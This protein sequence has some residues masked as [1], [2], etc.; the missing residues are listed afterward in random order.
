MILLTV[1]TAPIL[2]LLLLKLAA[3]AS[4]TDASAQDPAPAPAPVSAPTAPE[5]AAP[6]PAPAPPQRRPAFQPRFHD[7]STPI[8]EGKR[9]WVFSTGNG[10]LVRHSP[11]LQKWQDAPPVFKKLPEWHLE[12]V[13]DH[14][15][16]LWAPD[17]IKVQD[18]YLLYYSVS[19]WG[20]NTSAIGLASNRSLDP[21]HPEFEWKDQGIVIQS[22]PR[23]RFNAI[24]PHLFS[25]D[26]GRLWMSF[27]SFWSGIQLIE[28]DP[29]TGQRHPENRKIHHLAWSETIEAPAILKRDGFYYLFLNWGRC[30]RGLESTYEIRIG[31]SREI[32]GPYLDAD[33][34]ELVTGGGTLLLA[35][36]GDH[37]GPGHPAFVHEEEGK[38]RMFFHYYDRTRNGAPNI[39]SH[40][41]EWTA[42]GW[43]QILRK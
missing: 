12:V 28:L 20:K 40:L 29:A 4:I 10:I 24:D 13:P 1:R 42:D 2:L 43:P 39:G 31:R 22:T 30:C 26:D 16:H 23:E 8:L 25:D 34:V 9:W 14:R 17:L 11:D 32:T 18:H 36:E 7:P 37:V 3:C 5:P 35:S 21:E 41:L 33:G 19:G 27:G 38:T 6:E 15:G